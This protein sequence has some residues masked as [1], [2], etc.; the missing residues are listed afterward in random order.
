[1]HLY[2]AD[3]SL[4]SSRIDPDLQMMRLVRQLA[5]EASRR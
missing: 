3:R 5:E 2:H 1:L 4:K